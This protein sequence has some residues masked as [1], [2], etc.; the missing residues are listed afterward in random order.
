MSAYQTELIAVG[1]GHHLQQIRALIDDRS[2]C[3]PTC[4]DDVC[5]HRRE[6]VDLEVEVKAILHRLHLRHTLKRQIPNAGYV[7][8]R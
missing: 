6:V 4:L 2:D 1:I 3:G 7:V 8:Q 5:C